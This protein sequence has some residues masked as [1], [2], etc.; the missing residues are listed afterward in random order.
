M[1][2]R[3]GFVSNSSSSSFISDY[4]GEEYSGW[5]MDYREGGCV[6]CV[7]GHVFEDQHLVGITVGEI[8]DAVA[9]E[10]EKYNN[11]EL[12]DD[13][14]MWGE[15][16]FCKI[17]A[18]NCPCCLGLK[19]AKCDVLPFVLKKFGLTFEEAEEMLRKD[20]VEAAK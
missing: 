20:L 10:E 16:W 14:I 17:P 2:I 15:E 1:K 18:K 19:V 3:N 8:E 7:N 6:E 4:S 12:G 5:D 9:E 11:D 13:E